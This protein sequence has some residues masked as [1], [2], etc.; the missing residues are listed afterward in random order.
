MVDM[1]EADD[2]SDLDWLPE[3]LKNKR[4]KRKKEK[5]GKYSLSFLHI[6]LPIMQ[7]ER[8]KMLGVKVHC[9]TQLEPRGGSDVGFSSCAVPYYQLLV[10]EYFGFVPIVP[11]GSGWVG[12]DPGVRKLSGTERSPKR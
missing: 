6:S 7:S 12:R 11:S 5:K 9:T 4:D 3:K 8:P 10:S 1:F 2:P